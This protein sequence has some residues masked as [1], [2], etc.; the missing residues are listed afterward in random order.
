M[1]IVMPPLRRVFLWTAKGVW[2][3]IAG[4]T[5]SVGALIAVVIFGFAFG[6]GLTAALMPDTPAR[7][8]RQDR[9]APHIPQ[10]IASTP[11]QKRTIE[12]GNATS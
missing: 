6:I 11:I 9:P 1:K 2:Y 7:D 10:L 4:F 8:V 5:G 12:H 3:V